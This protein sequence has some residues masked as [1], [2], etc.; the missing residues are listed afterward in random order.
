MKIALNKATIVI[1]AKEFNP[2]IV[3]KDWLSREGIVQG[4][5]INFANV[6][7]FSFFESDNFIITVAPDRF[8]VVL[9]IAK[10]VDYRTLDL[11][12]LVSVAETF[13]E[14][15]PHTP[16]K[17]V[18]INYIWK[19]ESE[20]DENITSILKEKFLS[21][22]KMF[23]RLCPEKD[24]YV[25]SIIYFPHDGFKVKL[26]I[27][28]VLD[29]MKHITCNFN[30]NAITLSYKEVRERIEKAIENWSNSKNI[31]NTLLKKE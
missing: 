26:V 14:R 25:G 7:T 3:T 19:A 22:K 13:T 12:S 28:P 4:E 8:E 15:L 2:S 23:S 5:A 10:L 20:G 11:E 9:K 18:G 21:D 30:Y 1:L 24:S 16:Y 31:V 29:T 6:P 17:A 27:E